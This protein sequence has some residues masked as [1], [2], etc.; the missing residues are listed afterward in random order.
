MG[1]LLLST[2]A[3][4][5]VRHG[6]PDAHIAVMVRPYNEPVV[7]N[8][9][10]IDEVIVYD[11]DRADRGLW[12][13]ARFALRLFLKRFDT[14]VLLHTTNRAVL[15]SVFGGVKKIV[16]YDRRLR[17]LMTE[18]IQCEKHLGEKHEIDYSLDVVRKLGIDTAGADRRPVMVITE[19]DARS[20]ALLLKKKGVRHGDR[21]IVVNPG[22]SCPSRRWRPERYR[23]VIRRFLQAGD[24]VAVI[25]IVEEAEIAAQVLQGLEMRAL[26][27]TGL[28][29]IGET[30]A[31]I[32][33]ARLLVSNDTGS[34]H[35][36]SAVGTPVLVIYGRKDPGLS[37]VV[38][39]PIGEN[40][41]VL[42]K[43]AG[44]VTCL[45]HNCTNGFK[46]LDQIAVGDVIG[47]AHRIL[48]E[49]K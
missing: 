10:D 42:H 49:E 17:F 29:S 15:L 46:C 16:G 3:I 4:R 33:S 1:D 14:A 41:I 6:L 2:P 18:T 13:N 20:A 38:W 7:R 43:D 31:L 26:N 8:N 5:A 9:P 11:K 36:A 34:V 27:L 12:G 48:G 23:E 22:A 19:D 24:R 28:L 44:C 40:N 47:A 25:G 37:P 21:L 39:G 32:R 45:A 30:A 35:L